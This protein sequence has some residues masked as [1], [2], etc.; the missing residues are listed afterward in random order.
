MWELGRPDFRGKRRLAIRR[1]SGRGREK[2]IRCRGRRGCRWSVTHRAWQ[3]G[4]HWGGCLKYRKLKK[5]LLHLLFFILV[6]FKQSSFLTS[7]NATSQPVC[8]QLPE[9]AYLVL[10]F[11]SR[12]LFCFLC[13]FLDDS[14]LFVHEIV[15][16]V[17]GLLL[18]FHIVENEHVLKYRYF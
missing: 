8:I 5:N 17:T 9:I 2:S 14:A 10:L 6:S 3:G 18:F 16:R 7:F 1:G 13:L 11:L 4:V 12:L 15:R